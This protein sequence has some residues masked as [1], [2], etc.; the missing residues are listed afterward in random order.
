MPDPLIELGIAHHQAGRLDEAAAAYQDVLTTHPHHPDAWHLLGQVSHQRGQFDQAVAQIRQAIAHSSGPALYFTSLGVALMNLNQV[1]EAEAAYR[2]ALARGPVSAAMWLNLAECLRVQGRPDEQ[3]ACYRQALCLEPGHAPTHNNLG[4]ALQARGDFAEAAQCYQRAVER[5]PAFAQAWNNLA[6]MFNL[7]GDRASAVACYQ[8]GLALNPNDFVVLNNLGNVLRELGKFAEA[9]ACYHAA[10]ALNPAFV[11][12]HNNL[13]MLLRESGRLDGAIEAFRTALRLDPRYETAWRNLL[14]ALLYQCDI[15]QEVLFAEHRAFAETFEPGIT[16]LPADTAKNE[17][18]HRLRVAWVSSDFRDH[19]IARNVLPLLRHADRTRFEHVLYSDCPLPDALSRSIQHE[20]ALTRAITGLTD[21]Q[22]AT[23]MRADGIDILVTLA[24]HFDRN[25]PLIAAYC[26]AAIQVSL[27]DAASSGLQAQDYLISD[28]TMTP[29][30]GAERFT[31]RV[32]RL[33]V[34]YVHAPLAE[35][36][37]VTA[38]PVR[39][40]GYVTFGNFGNPAKI[41]AA[42]IAL[43]ARVLQAVPDSR[44]L[45]K[46]KNLYADGSIRAHFESAFAAHGIVPASIVWHGSS[47][48]AATQMAAYD[49]ADLVLDTFPF[50]GSTTTFEALWMGVPVLTLLGENMVGRWGASMLR[51]VDMSDWVARDAADYVAKAQ[52]HAGDI[53]TLTTLRAGLRARVAASPLCDEAGRA[54]QVERLLRAMWR[55]ACKNGL[56]TNEHE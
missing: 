16:A 50:N 20:A 1:A 52:Q 44:L 14:T 22:V 53:E 49:M 24:G 37:P 13:G 35:A 6:G 28:R 54:R 32:L 51:A 17:P 43:W 47:H 27:H 48:D 30:H 4:V 15:A 31:E 9:E 7:G 41:N 29:R 5:A 2:E 42:V 18:E 26:P 23:Q 38:L 10:L 12:C 3:I 55:R 40:N 8:R 21:A 25:R 56:T 39:A 11:E 45:L 33:P 36:P 19:P 34:F 46:Y